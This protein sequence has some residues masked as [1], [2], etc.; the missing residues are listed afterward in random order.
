METTVTGLFPDADSARR[1]RLELERGGARA[2]SIELITRETSHVHQLLGEETADAAR[3]AGIGALVGG[4]GAAV[5]G[6]ALALPPIALFA[7]PWFLSALVAGVCGAAGGA[8]IGLLIG[9]ATGHQVQEEYEHSIERGGVVLAV[10]TDRLHAAS[11]LS[12]L[13][14][15][16]GTALSTSVHRR[17]RLHASA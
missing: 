3:G 15:C 17:H 12:V 6:A 7:T 13:R 11:T 5:A 1:A 10:N 14:S 4:F 16:G 8:L 9:S 2:D